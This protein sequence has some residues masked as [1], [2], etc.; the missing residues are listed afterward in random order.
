MFWLISLEIMYDTIP[1]SC[2]RNQSTLVLNVPTISTETEKAKIKD[3]FGAFCWCWGWSWSMGSKTQFCLGKKN[4]FL[5]I[6]N[7]I[8][9]WNKKKGFWV[10]ILD[11]NNLLNRFW[12]FLSIVQCGNKVNVLFH[13]SEHYHLPATKLN[14]A[15]WGQMVLEKKYHKIA[16]RNTCNYSGN[17]KI[18]ILKSLLLTC[19]VSFLYIFFFVKIES[20]NF[21]HLYD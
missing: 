20:W 2:W 8:I 14:T 1:I 12:I 15:C 18:L 16:S 13:P 7:F 11:Y 17:Q 5:K 19:H 3:W 9:F 6:S 21:K 10:V 4:H